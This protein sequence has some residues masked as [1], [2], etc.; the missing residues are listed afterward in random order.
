MCLS[1]DLPT[2]GASLQG[3]ES[4]LTVKRALAPVVTQL[5]RKVSIVTVKQQGAI[6][7]WYIGRTCVSIKLEPVPN[8]IAP[9]G[10]IKE[11]TS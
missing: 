10:P 6:P 5:V 1:V 3:E 4:C 2:C 9:H 11:P 8:S 7:I